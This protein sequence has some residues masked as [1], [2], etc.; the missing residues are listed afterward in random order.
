VKDTI[1]YFKGSN[2]KMRKIAEIAGD[3]TDSEK[4]ADALSEINKFCEERDFTIHYIRSWNTVQDEKP[5][6]VFDAGSHTEFFYAEPAIE[7]IDIW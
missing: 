7:Y 4:K 3:K 6:T 2:G 5:M 1:L